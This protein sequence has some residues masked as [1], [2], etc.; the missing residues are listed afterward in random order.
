MKGGCLRGAA[1]LF[2]GVLLVAAGALA[3][4]NRDGLGAAWDR[5]FEGPRSSPELAAQAEEKLA[6]LGGADGVAQV[7]LNG[8]ELQSLIDYRWAGFLPDDV[9]D[10]RVE[11]AD[12][13]VTLEAGVARAR[14]AQIRDL[15]E[16]VAFLPDTTALRAVTTFTPLSAEKVALEV[17]ELGA[18]GIPVP[19]RLIPLIL[20]RFRGSDEP[21]LPPNALAIPLPAGIR[22]VYAEGDSLVFQAEIGEV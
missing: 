15:E 5:V 17:H 8:Q 19:R 2:A 1:R 10:P 3:W 7:A 9:V 13:R 11:V 12:G 16:I 20:G 6:R 14:F 4:A 22:N 21:G 18:A